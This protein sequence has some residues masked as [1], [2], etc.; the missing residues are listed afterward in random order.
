MVVGT[1]T[2]LT[3]MP[4]CANPPTPAQIE[5]KYQDGKILIEEAYHLM[6]ASCRENYPPGSDAQTQCL[7]AADEWRQTQYTLALAARDDA[8]A[9]NW[10]SARRRKEQ[11]EKQLQD[12]LPNWPEIKEL[13]TIIDNGSAQATGTPGGTRFVAADTLP[14]GAAPIGGEIPVPIELQSYAFI[15]QI[16]FDWGGSTVSA[17]FSGT[18]NI[19]GSQTG[20]S[21][22]GVVRSGTLEATFPGGVGARLV[23]VKEPSNIISTD[24]SGEGHMVFLADLEHDLESWDSILS[25]RYRIFVPI[26]VDAQGVIMIDTTS[27]QIASMLPYAPR[28]YTDY[29]LDGTY[30]FQSD[31]NAFIADFALHH[32][33]TDVNLDGIWNQSDVDQW[34]IEFNEDQAGM[35][36]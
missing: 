5:Q 26:T 18:L 22:S 4:G 25:S 29:N 2:A 14:G 15:G 32:P 27:E 24:A 11:L 30:D 36:P 23:V 34:V 19:H 21:Y 13:I 17:P 7:Q 35:N 33:A 20:L 1:C 8:Y 28:P 3:L 6:V 9:E 31:F 16:Q 12:M 10:A